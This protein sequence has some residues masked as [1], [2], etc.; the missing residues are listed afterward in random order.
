MLSSAVFLRKALLVAVL[1]MLCIPQLILEL[2]PFAVSRSVRDI[3]LTADAA[4]CF[5]AVCA[6][7]LLKRKK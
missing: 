6:A 3:L 4:A 5:T 2:F 1:I 7:E